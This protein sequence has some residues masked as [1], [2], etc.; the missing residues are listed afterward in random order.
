MIVGFFFGC[1]FAFLFFLA[2]SWMVVLRITLHNLGVVRAHRL[3]R[4]ETRRQARQPIIELG[5]SLPF[6]FLSS[7]FPQRLPHTALPCI[8]IPYCY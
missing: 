4:A 1:V 2:S 7:A 5:C 8:V 6:R 3:L